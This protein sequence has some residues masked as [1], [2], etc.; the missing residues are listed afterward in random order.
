M[1]R[2]SHS[3][4]MFS[5]SVNEVRGAYGW[6]FCFFEAGLFS[7]WSCEENTLFWLRRTL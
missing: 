1:Y 4:V 5:E 2:L 7:G 3:A 6:L